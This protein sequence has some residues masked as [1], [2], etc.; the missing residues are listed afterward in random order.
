MTAPADATSS[1]KQQASRTARASGKTASIWVELNM[2]GTLVNEQ[3]GDEK[4][5][6]ETS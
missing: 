1:G 4:A 2:T 3:R 5:A 6:P